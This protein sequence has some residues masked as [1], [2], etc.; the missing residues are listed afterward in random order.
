MSRLSFPRHVRVRRRAE[1]TA[2][3]EHGRRYH[4][5]HFLL[6]VLPREHAGELTRTGMAVSR[7]VGNA[8][9]RNRVKRLL[10]EF[11]RLHSD[12]LPAHADLVAV[13]K[14]HAGGDA[15]DLSRV[16]AEFL[17][18]LRRIVRPRRTAAACD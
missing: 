5:E 8:V 15:L 6:F 7:K 17:P 12:L 10:R 3:Y 18:L 16:S 11:F 13:A 1:F 4:T 9:V 14:R 2:C